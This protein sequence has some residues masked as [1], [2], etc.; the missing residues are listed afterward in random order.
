VVSVL[1][2][3]HYEENLLDRIDELERRVGALERS[4]A[5]GLFDGTTLQLPT[6]TEDLE[7]VDAGSTGATEQGWIEVEVDGATGYLRVFAAK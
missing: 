2:R 3:D 1:D 5:T 7:I 4:A 6:P